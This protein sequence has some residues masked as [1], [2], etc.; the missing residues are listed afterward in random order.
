MSTKLYYSNPYETKWTTDIEKIIEEENRTFVILKETAFYPEGGGQPADT[1]TINGIRVIDVQIKN[2]QIYHLVENKPEEQTVEC[3]IDW[4]RRFDHMQQHTAQ[5]LLS[6]V[7]EEL[8]SIPTVSFHLGKEYTTIDVDTTD[9]T[10]EQIETIETACN[11][12]IMKNLEIKTYFTNHEEV[13]KFPLRKLPEVTGDIR[14]VEIEG[15]D[16]SACAGTHVQRT[17][18]LSFFKIMKT[19]KHR[20]QIRVFFL[21]GW[22]SLYDYQTSQTILD[23]LSSHFKTN[24]QQLEDRINKLELEKKALN[25]EVEVLKSENTAFLGEQILADQNE[26]IIFLQ[27]EEKTMKD[28]STLAKYI[29]QQSSYIILLSSQLEK[30]V[31][32]QHNGDYS[33]HCG[34][35]LKEAIKDFEGK[36]GGNELLA[37]ATFPSIQQLNACTSKIKETLQSIL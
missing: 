1:G 15:I 2:D 29:I 27:F 28:L 9:L 36:G 32:L 26:K 24:K 31:L 10:K 22:R 30:K 18:E 16:Y 35:L 3:V 11:T 37:Q 17:G 34:K 6:A 33:L 20:G 7:L 4:N 5:H 8:Y 14:I 19:E 21:S 12:Y 23:H 25:R 13:N